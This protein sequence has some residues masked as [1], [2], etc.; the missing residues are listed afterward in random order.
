MKSRILKKKEEKRNEMIL[1]AMADNRAAEILK[2]EG[3]G[4][5]EAEG[6]E[7]TYQMTQD[8]LRKEVDVNTQRKMFSL[9]LDQFGPYQVHFDRPGRHLLMSGEKGHIAM[10]CCAML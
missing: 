10:V 5:I 8:R 7:R 3:G 6:M 1:N 2:T 4:Y 9:T